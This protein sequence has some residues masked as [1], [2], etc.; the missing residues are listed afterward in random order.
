M[1]NIVSS[2]IDFHNRHL[3]E[4]TFYL[5]SIKSAED[6]KKIQLILTDSVRSIDG[7]HSIRWTLSM[8]KRD[9]RPFA[10]VSTIF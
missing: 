6:L 9:G 3:L 7:Q 8:Q 5:I 10:G 4:R 2:F 1:S